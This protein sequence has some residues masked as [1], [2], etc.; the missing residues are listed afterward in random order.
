MQIFHVTR[1][2]EWHDAVAAGEYRLSTRGASLDEVGFIHASSREQLPVVARALY[3]GE[4]ADL[5]VLVMDEG[6]LEAA[7]LPVRREDGGDGELYPHVY[8]AIPTAL[9][10]EVRPA[11]EL[12]DIQ[13]PR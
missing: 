5:V 1:A 9:V 11:V 7:G 12:F 3:A 10:Q 6:A 13:G 2:S 8:G 4:D